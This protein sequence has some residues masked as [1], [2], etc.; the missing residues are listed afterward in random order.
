[1]GVCVGEKRHGSDGCLVF[2]CANALVKRRFEDF[3]LLY[4][5]E[6]SPW[7]P[8][9]FHCALVLFSMFFGFLSSFFNDGDIFIFLAK[10]GFFVKNSQR[11][12]CIS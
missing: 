8:E 4:S 11:Y 7:M 5:D 3:Y 1:M 6:Y 10:N 9:F 12:T 2:L